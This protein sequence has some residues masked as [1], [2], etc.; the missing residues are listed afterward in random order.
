[1]KTDYIIQGLYQNKNWYRIDRAD[2]LEEAKNI[3]KYIKNYGHQ[4]GI[5]YRIVERK[6]EERILEND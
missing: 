6:I 5:E 3:I 4:F 1:M 2:S